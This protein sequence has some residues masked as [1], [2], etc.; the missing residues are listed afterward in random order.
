MK[1]Y[2][3]EGRGGCWIYHFI[4][5]NLGGLYNIINKINPRN[6]DSTKLLGF[7]NIYYD[8]DDDIQYPIP[9]IIDGLTNGRGELNEWQ[10][11]I[12]KYLNT[13]IKL[14][15]LDELKP[16]DKIISIYGTTLNQNI[17]CDN[18]QIYFPFLRNLLLENIDNDNI[19]QYKG[20][21]FFLT[22]K[23]TRQFHNGTLK[24]YILN[25][26][27]LMIVLEKYNF[28]YI[29][30]ENLNI[31]NKIKLFNNADVI[32][33]SNIGGFVFSLVANNNTKIIEIVNKSD[34]I[35]PIHYKLICDTLGISYY[36]YSNIYEDHYGNFNI[37]TNDFE[38]YIH[39]IL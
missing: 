25:E 31:Q 9:I 37:N 30:L 28:E 27:D 19:E 13:K 14:I 38:K 24:K 32:L 21:R 36:R 35:L 22:R 34:G 18:P 33:S 2:Y 39:S 1:V 5:Y 4:V 7:N 16:N 11:D 17:A 20:K 23:Y 10:I 26:D 15:K 3:L 12:C 8:D 6:K 29:I